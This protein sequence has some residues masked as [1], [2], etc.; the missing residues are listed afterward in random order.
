MTNKENG[1]QSCGIIVNSA[2]LTGRNF[3]LRTETVAIAEV[4]GKGV[5]VSIPIGAVIKV[6]SGPQ[7]SDGLVDVLWDGRVVQMFT[8]DIEARGKE[9]S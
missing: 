4:D 7:H 8:V 1:V 6:V 5:A 2:M 3:R 9:I